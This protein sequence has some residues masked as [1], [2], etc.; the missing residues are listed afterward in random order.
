[1]AAFPDGV[2]VAGQPLSY[3]LTTLSKEDLGVQKSSIAMAAIAATIATPL[4]AAD[5]IPVAMVGD[6]AI[7]IDPN[8]GNGCLTQVSLSD[9]STL[10][11]GFDKPG[12]GTGYVSSFNPAWAQFVRGEPY[13]VT[14]TFGDT[15]FVG[16]GRG[17]ELAGMPGVVVQA[18][19]LDLLRELAQAESVNL[20][21]GGPGIDVALKGSHDALEA[22]LEC[23]AAQ[24]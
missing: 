23:Q 17:E 5:L 20:S 6:W 12:D 21:A 10:R 7:L 9:G 14:M 8:R 1:M 19:N 3:A 16:R 2:I 24:M 15:T 11:I 22:A 4:L 13:D 18:D